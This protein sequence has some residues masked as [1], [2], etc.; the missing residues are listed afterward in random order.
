[1]AQALTLRA[2][3]TG[4]AFV[5]TTPDVKNGR[6]HS[7]LLIGTDLTDVLAITFEVYVSNAIIS[8]PHFGD[9][10]FVRGN[11]ISRIIN[12][13]LVASS[14]LS[15]CTVLL[16]GHLEEN[17]HP[18][19]ETNVIFDITGII[20]AIEDRTFT[21]TTGS[22]DSAARGVIQFPVSILIPSAPRWQNIHIPNI[23]APLQVSARYRDTHTN[24]LQFDLE[25][26]G[27]LRSAGP[28]SSPGNTKKRSL[29]NRQMNPDQT[30]MEQSEPSSS[31]TLAASLGH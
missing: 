11:L 30:V 2:N 31:S 8:S 23:G 28:L 1:M 26:L 6:L 14:S 16:T 19:L 4:Y 13:E 7:E 21:L 3:F 27:Y 22:F 20:A 5:N 25:D 9:L 29:F 12:D 10:L 17:M 18:D 15:T 24:V